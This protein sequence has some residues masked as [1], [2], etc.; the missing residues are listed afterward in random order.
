MADATTVV[1]VATAD[2]PA[3]KTTA[4]R[5]LYRASGARRLVFSFIFLLLLPFFVSLP[6]MLYMRVAHGLWLD[7][8]GLLIIAAAFAILMLLI[9]MELLFSVRSRVELGEKAVK[10]T[11]PSGRGP[12]PMLRYARHEVPY[13]QIKSV[14]TRREVYG[15]ALTPMMLSGARIITKDDKSVRLGYVNEANVDPVFPYLDIAQQIADRAGV[16]VMHRGSVRRSMQRKMLGLA[17]SE[18]DRGGL[19]EE[20]VAQLNRQHTKLMLALTGALALLIGAGILSDLTAEWSSGART[21]A[22]SA[23]VAV[24]PPKK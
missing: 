19:D 14:E 8:V 18:A 22:V 15:G 9:V 12:T 1:P 16:P 20:T 3:P 21:A 7:T 24:K 5:T 13:D 23:P 2:T 10:L 4:E 6:A 11:L 17:A